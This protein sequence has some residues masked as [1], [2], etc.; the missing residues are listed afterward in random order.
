[1]PT[2]I[3]QG[4]NL[5]PVILIFQVNIMY[6]YNLIGSRGSGPYYVSTT[7]YI[8]LGTL[9]TLSYLNPAQHNEKVL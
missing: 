2:E 4:L 5:L 3:H 8:G 9:H 6:K 1:M 7:C